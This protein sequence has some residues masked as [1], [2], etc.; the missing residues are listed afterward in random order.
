M[1]CFRCLFFVFFPQIFS[2]HVKLLYGS[3]IKARV[4]EQEVDATKTILCLLDSAP[5]LSVGHS[6]VPEFAPLRS[7]VIS[8]LQVTSQLEGNIWAFGKG[9]DVSGMEYSVFNSQNTETDQ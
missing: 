9:R 2:G 4:S 5:V 3:V 7:L 6:H 1:T 8:W